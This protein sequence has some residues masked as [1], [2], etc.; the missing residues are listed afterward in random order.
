M[1]ARSH[2]PWPDFPVVRSLN[3]RVLTVQFRPPVRCA[4][5]SIS[6]LLPRLSAGLSCRYGVSRNRKS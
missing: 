6:P 5:A 4:A 1:F 2:S 3:I